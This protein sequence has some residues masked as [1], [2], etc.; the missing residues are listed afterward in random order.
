MLIFL[1]A[2]VA[3]LA[4]IAHARAVDNVSPHLFAV[5]LVLIV[6]AITL[7]AVFF[8]ASNR[9]R[10]L[11]APIEQEIRSNDRK[12]RWLIWLVRLAIVVLIGLLLIGLLYVR[13]Q[14]LAPRLVGLAMN[15]SF[16]V[17]LVI[18]LRRLQAPK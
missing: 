14:P 10:K 2:V 6:T 18:T 4:A 7:G 11:R 3:I 13:E 8:F 17:A 12:T 15:L 5:I 16:I 9:T 1:I